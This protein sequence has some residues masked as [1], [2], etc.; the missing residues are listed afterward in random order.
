MLLP[1][2]CLPNRCRHRR[3]CRCC[4]RRHSC[5]C[6]PFHFPQNFP[7]CATSSAPADL[8]LPDCLPARLPACPLCLPCLQTSSYL[9]AR[10]ALCASLMC[11]SAPRRCTG[12]RWQETTP[13]CWVGVCVV[14]GW[15]ADGCWLLGASHSW[16]TGSVPAACQCDC[17]GCR[18]PGVRCCASSWP[19]L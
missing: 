10:T 13:M 17:P 2:A 3:A 11:A 14:G 15:L 9:P 1:P 6:P 5:P 18:R 12:R 8:L 7:W 4:C 19:A 16:S